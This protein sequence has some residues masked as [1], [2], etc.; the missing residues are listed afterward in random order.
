MQGP[1]L[2]K[3]LTRDYSDKALKVMG[4]A[5]AYNFDQVFRYIF[6]NIPKARVVVIGGSDDVCRSVY[7]ACAENK[8][9]ESIHDTDK[10]NTHGLFKTIVH[11][12]SLVDVK[13]KF[14]LQI[15]DK[16]KKT[17]DYL[18]LPT[19]HEHHRSYIRDYFN[20]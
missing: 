14:K 7:E 6:N 8:D 20:H 13:P 16:D 17:G 3:S 18:F 4:S 11:F 2:E 10:K 9:V 19:Y 1:P 5:N 15:E 12:D